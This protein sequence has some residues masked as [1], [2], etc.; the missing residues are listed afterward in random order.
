MNILQKILYPFQGALRQSVSSFIRLE[1][2]DNEFTLAASDG[3]LVSYLKVDGSRQII[4]EEEYNFLIDAATIKLGSKF[5]RPGHAMQIYFSR[6]PARIRSHL[7]ILNRPVFATASNI[8]LEIGDLIDE[9]VKNL[10]TILSHEESYFVLWTRPS[11]MTKSEVQRVREE[12]Q[13][14]NKKWVNATYGQNPLAGVESLRTRHKSYTTA[15]QQALDEMGIRAEFLDAHTA[16]RAVRNNMFPSRANEDWRAC[17]PGDPIPPRSPLNQFDLSDIIWPSIPDQI[18]VGDARLIGGPVVQID[19]LNWAGADMTLG[20]MEVAPFPMLLN[21]LYDSKVPFRISLLV[22]G[23]GVEATAFKTLVATLMSVTNVM[24]KQI[25]YSLEGLQALARS[26]PVVKLRVSFATWAPKSEPNLIQDRLSILMQSVESWGYAQVSSASGDPLDCVMSSAMGIHCA[27]TAPLAIAPMREV[28]KLVPWQRP[29]SP[30]SLGAIMLRT[31]DGKVWPYQTG[32]NLT[33]TWFDLI[34]A[35][36][37]AGK[38]VLMNTL[39]LGTILTPGLN[40][41][42]FIAIIDIGP[43]SSGLVSLVKEALPIERQFES[44]YYRLQMSRSYAINPFDTQLGCRYPLIDERSYL[45][46]LMTLLCTPPGNEKPYDGIPQLSSLVVDEMYRWRDDNMANAEP[47][48]YLPRLDGDIDDAIQKH[49]I[50]L[51]TDPYWWD[52]VEALFDRGLYMDAIR[53]QRHAMP[54]LNDAITAARRPQIRSLLEETSIGGSSESVISA[55][56]RMVTSAV[57]D[58]PILSSVT[59]FDIAG[60]RICSLDLMDISPQGDDTADR[61]TAVMYMLA[62]QALVRAWWVGKESLPFMPEKFRDYHEVNLQDMAESP[63]R[64]CYDEFHRTSS[65]SSVRAQVVRDVREGRKRGVQIVLASQLLGDFDDDMVDLATGVWV[66]GTAVSDKAVDD[67]RDRFGLSTTARNIIRFR[68][69]GP[70]AGGAPALLILGTNEGRY[71]Q[72]LINTLGPI[73]LWAFATSVE[74]VIIR[75]RLYAKFGAGRARQMLA[76]SFPGGSARN[77]LKRRVLL[78]S[79]SGDSKAA[80]LSAIIDELVDELIDTYNKQALAGKI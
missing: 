35:Q 18:S 36:P 49:N 27:G 48:P 39:N 66:L 68:L 42:P 50:H 6:D 1:T 38:S 46:E 4:G 5:D 57:R 54:T 45:T 47:R 37:G 74:D 22:E 26:E 72:H 55:F 30:F 59:Q 33:T 11:S 51:P 8:G 28:M 73:E 34:F 65:S 13:A 20:P 67:I 25:K 56:E 15:I 21:R 23:G 53:A 44:S 69:T 40:K 60:A 64:L 62:R 58:F 14:Q 63:K 70:R 32:T 19:D 17:L 76:V 7:D 29:S 41:L 52:V 3:S 9:K 2:L 24:N 31:P 61:Q 77:E 43:S 75:N 16:L 12:K 71:E 80:A 79:D 78:K 10:S